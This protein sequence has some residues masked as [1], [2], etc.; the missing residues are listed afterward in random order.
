ME[1]Y[2]NAEER[3]QSCNYMKRHTAFMDWKMWQRRQFSPDSAT[4]W[5][6]SC[7]IGLMGFQSPK[8][9]LVGAEKDFSKSNGKGKGMRTAKT[10]W[11]RRKKYYCYDFLHN[12]GMRRAW[13]RQTSRRRDLW[14]RTEN[15]NTPSR[16][17][18]SDFWQRWK[19]HSKGK[20]VFFSTNGAGATGRSQ[21][22]TKWTSTFL[23]YI[24]YKNDLI[25]DQRH[26]CKM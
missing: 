2:K 11:K 22:K 7:Q 15:T 14:T 8:Y 5:C 24:L 10:F 17:R 21:G 13:Y 6:E 19:C 3:K 25:I 26:I 23:W 4:V 9:F 16:M 1:N 12:P 20:G 18:S